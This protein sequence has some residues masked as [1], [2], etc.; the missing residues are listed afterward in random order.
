[1]NRRKYLAMCC[2]SAVSN[3]FANGGVGG[4]N[5][6]SVF[7]QDL[8]LPELI[9]QGQRLNDFKQQLDIQTIIQP[10]SKNLLK[11]QVLI[12]AEDPCFDI[13]KIKITIDDPNIKAIDTFH[14]LSKT[15]NKKSS[16]IVGQCIGT[17]SLQNIVT[18]SQN[19]LIK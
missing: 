9:R 15:L 7:T 2:L 4:S 16:A 3:T 11:N 8:S 1:M 13:Q 18:F 14:F 6:Q 10:T 12:V 5:V 17:Q 19:E